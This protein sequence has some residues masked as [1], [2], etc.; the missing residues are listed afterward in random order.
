M[1]AEAP[2]TL[3]DKAVAVAKELDKH[4]IISEALLKIGTGRVFVDKG[5]EKD[6]FQP[7]DIEHLQVV[8]ELSTFGMIYLSTIGT[9][10]CSAED[11]KLARDLRTFNKEVRRGK[12]SVTVFDIRG[13]IG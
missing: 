7:S 13:K 11:R 2:K 8:P 6:V 5:K 10:F 12:R 9:L 1:S 4:P 3:G